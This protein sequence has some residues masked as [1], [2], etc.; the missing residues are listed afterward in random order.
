MCVT[1]FQQLSIFVIKSCKSDLKDLKVSNYK[2]C[3]I[4]KNLYSNYANLLV[5][6][7]KL[8]IFKHSLFS[9]LEQETKLDFNSLTLF[10]LGFNKFASLL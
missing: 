8:N 1:M 7:S 5:F 4:F 10:G 3:P 6:C 9:D 2:Y